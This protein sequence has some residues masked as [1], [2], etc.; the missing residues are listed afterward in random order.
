MTRHAFAGAGLAILGA[1]FFAAGCGTGASLVGGACAA[2]YTQCGSQCVDL[3]SD[4][5]NCGACGNV[6][7]EAVACALSACGGGALED[8]TA[9]QD[10][11]EEAA[12][13]GEIVDASE[14]GG[15]GPSV[16]GQPTADGPID[17][18]AASAEA[19]EGAAGL[20]GSTAGLDGSTAGLD[21]SAPVDS[22]VTDGAVMDASTSDGAGAGDAT[23]GGSGDSTENDGASEPAESGETGDGEAGSE[24][25]CAPLVECGG[26]CVDLTQDTANCGACANSCYSGICKSSACVGA[27]SGVVVLV[28]HNFV[29]YSPAQ[30]HLL[31][32][33]VLLARGA[34]VPVLTYERYSNAATIASIRAIASSAVTEI[35]RSV[36]LTETS[37]D[38]DVTG[39]Q[40]G[41]YG[42]L[43]VLDQPSAPSGALASL[44]QTWAPGLLAYLQAGGVVVLLDG[45]TGV[46]EMPALS[47][48]AGLLSVSAHQP[49]ATLTPLDVVARTDAVA[50]GVGTTYAAG[51]TTASF[52]TESNGG[53]VVYVVM[54]P[55]DVSPV[56]VHKVF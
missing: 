17:G 34:S 19:S 47:S 56:V 45:D 20:E 12:P 44:G 48:S 42:V 24:G 8:A 43:L 15:D 13:S 2:G 9:P 3:R 11:A 54:T 37:A 52:T 33:A 21:G 7:D 51:F 30:A 6:C 36:V 14:E 49:V 50:V 10:G 5:D 23:D 4:P 32:N 29:A 25:H 31:L 18:P 55:G 16:E 22:S 28:G 27:G 41:Q 40:V 39:I 53:N 46:G 1:L 26:F 38:S 35:G